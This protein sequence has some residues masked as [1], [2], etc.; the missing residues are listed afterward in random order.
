MI[1]VLPGQVFQFAAGSVFGF[2]PGLLISI[3]GAAIGA[4]VTYHLAKFLGED[5]MHQIFG[6]ERMQEYVK[7]LNSERAYLI[8]F[9]IYLIPGLPKDLVCYAAGM[10]DMKYRAFIL[11]STVGRIPG[12]CGSLL[13]GHMFMQKN[14]TGMIIVAIVA[15]I[16]LLL[17]FLFRKRL[18]TWMDKVYVKI[19]K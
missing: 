9:L 4:T 18:R 12:M 2:L 11:L 1:S 7:R 17:C 5:A 8:V 15:G 14:Y 16:I 6:E 13:F 19:S 3:A 10:S